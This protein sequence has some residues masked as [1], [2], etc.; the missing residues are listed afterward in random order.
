MTAWRPIETPEGE[1]PKAAA[2]AAA[3]PIAAPLNLE[4]YTGKY[5]VRRKYRGHLR[6]KR[7]QTEVRILGAEPGVETPRASMSFPRLLAI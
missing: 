5:Q 3:S 1:K 2:S 4:L 6:Q 7:G